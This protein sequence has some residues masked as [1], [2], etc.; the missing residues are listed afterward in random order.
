MGESKHECQYCSASF[1]TDNNLDSDLSCC[2]ECA[3]IHKLALAIKDYCKEREGFRPVLER[4]E[5]T[6]RVLGEIK[7]ILNA[8][9]FII[10]PSLTL[11][12]SLYRIHPRGELEILYFDLKDAEVQ[13][14]REAHKTFF[15][16][17]YYFIRLAYGDADCPMSISYLQNLF[18]ENELSY[19]WLVKEIDGK[20]A[21]F[22]TFPVMKKLDKMTKALKKG[23][24]TVKEAE[25]SEES[26]FLQAGEPLPSEDMNFSR[27][28]RAAK[29]AYLIYCAFACALGEREIPSFGTDPALLE[30]M[31]EVIVHK[32]A[33]EFL[34]F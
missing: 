28:C 30:A 33:T 1:E 13:R 8:Y 9:R 10:G 34:V 3:Q 6:R 21:R 5:E 31:N 26:L 15:D 4:S 20:E 24:E 29:S 27:L 18:S 32:T 17:V 16:R 14:E 22:K 25:D 2:K 23:K 12:S 7:Q 11:M 19:L